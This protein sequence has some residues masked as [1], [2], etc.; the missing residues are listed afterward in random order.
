MK[1]INWI[2][3]AAATACLAVGCD[4]Y[5]DVTAPK[6]NNAAVQFDL[7][8]PSLTDWLGDYD[9]AEV[10][11]DDDGN[12]VGT[13][14]G[15]L[16]LLSLNATANPNVYDATGTL[17][18]TGTATDGETWPIVESFE[19]PMQDAQCADGACLKG[20]KHVKVHCPPGLVAK[21]GK[22]AC[23]QTPTAHK[24]KKK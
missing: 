21:I 11:T 22:A 14:D 1:R 18:G 15:T 10:I 24:K 4:T 20:K 9:D 12:E 19:I 8:D 17:S 2:V 13:F 16:T 23:F 5:R 6:A 7:V 3:A